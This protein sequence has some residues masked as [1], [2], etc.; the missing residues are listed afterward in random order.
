MPPKV[1]KKAAAKKEEQIKSSPSRAKEDCLTLELTSVTERLSSLMKTVAELRQEREWLQQELQT[2]KQDMQDYLAYMEKKTTKIDN[3]MGSLNDNNKE[4]I[5]VI[6]DEK[7]TIQEDFE[8]E[9]HVSKNE[10]LEKDVIL[11]RTRQQLCE[12][13]PLKDIQREQTECI[14]H[15]EKDILQMRALHSN[16]IQSLKIRFLKQKQSFERQA[17]KQVFGLQQ[18]ACKEAS[19]CLG[20]HIQSIRD[21][22]GRRRHQLL[23]LIRRTR[24]L[25]E[26]RHQLEEQRSELLREKELTVDLKQIKDAKQA[27][28]GHTRLVLQASAQ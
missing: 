27:S 21:E 20:D 22:N 8:R 11:S 28:E 23:Q 1:K 16:S 4:Q 12:L 6:L 2:T 18:L 24:T 26:H 13:Q 9:K 17:D 15:L 10:L 19:R 14:Q 3:A 5:Q 7:S 25:H